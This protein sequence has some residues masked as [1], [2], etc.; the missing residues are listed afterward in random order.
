TSC[1][2]LVS[3]DALGTATATD[4][5]DGSPAVHRTG[6]PSGNQFPV[7]VTNVAYTATDSSGNTT[8]ATQTVTVT[9]DTF[10]TIT[11]PADASY[12]LSSLVPAAD[13]SRATTFDNCG[14]AMVTVHDSANAGEGTP[15]SPLV[16]TRL[17]T[18]V[19]TSGNAAVATQIIRVIDTTP[20]AIA[21]PADV[22]VGTGLTAVTCSTFIGDARLGNAT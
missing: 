14:I 18:T 16:I 13:P 20:P 17:F 9:D 21:A 12:Q 1:D 15:V 2:T 8:T 22:I 7:G 11:A 6:V 10:P 19:D 4:N 5:V 3:D